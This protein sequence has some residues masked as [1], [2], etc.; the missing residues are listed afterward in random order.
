MAHS[1]NP[2]TWEAEA[3]R[4]L[5]SKTAGSTE[6]VP[7]QQVL[8]RES[9]SQGT[10]KKKHL[11]KITR[12]HSSWSE[13]GAYIK[14]FFHEASEITHQTWAC[15]KPFCHL[16]SSRQLQTL[17]PRNDHSNITQR[18][19]DWQ[20]ATQDLSVWTKI[21]EACRDYFEIE[22]KGGNGSGQKTAMKSTYLSITQGCHPCKLFP[23]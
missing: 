5:N 21:Y 18:K 14:K 6:W 16:W 7:W 17:R 9:L 2:S 12:E 8:H 19:W 13:L 4:F 3:G 23:T 1:F 11:T 10:E 22:G 20:Y 15:E